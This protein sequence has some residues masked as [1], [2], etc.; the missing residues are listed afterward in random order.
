MTKSIRHFVA[1]ALMTG[2]AA[3]SGCSQEPDLTKHISHTTIQSEWPVLLPQSALLPETPEAPET[4]E[5]R[6]E[7]LAQAEV[8]LSKPALTA[9]ER[10]WLRAILAELEGLS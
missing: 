2:A 3:V 6:L 8:L 7:L 10:S 4:T 5:R 1:V 9:S